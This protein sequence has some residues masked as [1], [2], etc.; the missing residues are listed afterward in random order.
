MSCHHWYGSSWRVV[1]LRCIRFLSLA[2]GPVSG[3]RLEK[4]GDLEIEARETGRLER[5]GNP[6]TGRLS[7]SQSLGLS[8][9]FGFS[10]SGLEALGYPSLQSPGLPSRLFF[11]SL[12]ISVPPVSESGGT[13]IPKEQGDRRGTETQL[14]LRN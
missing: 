13:G 4:Q 9:S 5:Q 14:G 2:L 1:I 10:L 12:T 11:W 6:E 3:W 8:M 7:V